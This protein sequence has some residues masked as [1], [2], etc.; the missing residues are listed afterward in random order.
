MKVLT[1][2]CREIVV[3]IIRN[4][5]R[6]ILPTNSGIKVLRKIIFRS[7]LGKILSLKI[8]FKN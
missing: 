8:L 2:I 1:N 5:F 6:G 7:A 3:M 4:M